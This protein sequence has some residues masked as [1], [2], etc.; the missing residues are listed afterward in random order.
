MEK[1]LFALMKRAKTNISVVIEFSAWQKAFPFKTKEVST[2]TDLAKFLFKPTR[3]N[4]GGLLGFSL[5]CFLSIYMT[6]KK[7][8]LQ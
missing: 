1:M 3:H 4:S 2:E 5:P 6:K 7:E 8:K